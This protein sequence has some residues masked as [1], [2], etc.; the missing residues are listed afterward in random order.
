MRGALTTERLIFCPRDII[1]Q[2]HVPLQAFVYYT[3]FDLYIA[4]MSR[5]EFKV[6]SH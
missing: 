1:D 5:V 3:L 4:I 6:L 2:N